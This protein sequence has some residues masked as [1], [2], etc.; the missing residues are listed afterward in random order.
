MPEL[1]THATALPYFA[2]LVRETQMG[3]AISTHGVAA[4]R[5]PIP[6]RFALHKLVVAQL[7]TGRSEKSLKDLRQAAVL[8][9]ALGELYPGALESA[10]GKTPRSR[11]KDIRKSLQQIRG[12]LEPHPQAWDE[13]ASAANPF[14]ST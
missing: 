3:A 10:Y 7:R 14:S 8:I 2:Y 12:Q 6:E 9:A 4:V 13:I 1:K 5:V 11:H